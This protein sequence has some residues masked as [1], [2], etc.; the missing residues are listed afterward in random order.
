MLLFVPAIRRNGL[1]RHGVY[2]AENRD[3]CIDYLQIL[4]Y[5]FWEAKRIQ[6]GPRNLKGNPMKSIH[7]ENEDLQDL[8]LERLADLCAQE[9]ELFFQGRPVEAQGCYEMFRRAIV[10]REEQA[11]ERVYRQYRSVALA[12]IYRHPSFASTGEEAQY[13]VNRAFEKMWSAV[14]PAKFEQ[15]PDL[16]SLLRYLQICVHSAIVDYARQKDET[17]LEME[18][19]PPLE[20][21]RPG[22]GVEARVVAQT[23]RQE[24]WR[25]VNDR[26]KNDKEQTILYASFVLGLKPRDLYDWFGKRFENIDEVYRVK[27][28]LLRRLRRDVEL[29]SILL[30]LAGR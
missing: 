23:Q 19:I 7:P 12:W 22:P 2:G 18:E 15:F 29:H 20:K 16:K 6:R 8:E 3:L 10:E 11:W 24:I 21:Q 9:S 14:T 28:N 27:E 25:V 5:K 4:G 26:I 30:E 13:F 1:A 17:H